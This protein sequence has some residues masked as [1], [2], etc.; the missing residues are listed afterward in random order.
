MCLRKI[1]TEREAM[2]LTI[3]KNKLENILNECPAYETLAARQLGNIIRNAMTEEAELLQAS[4]PV[5]KVIHTIGTGLLKGQRIPKVMLD[6]KY[7][8]LP[9][10]T[11][12]YTSPPNT[13]QEPDKS[14]MAMLE[15]TQHKLDKAREAL[16]W[17]S[18]NTH[19]SSQSL[20]FIAK[21]ALKEIE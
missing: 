16:E 20:G 1:T 15:N 6:V 4:E 21:D 13:P 9:A 7:V 5:A 2:K 8:D 19:V 18:N 3:D 10:G 17:I 14:F 12:L 11:L